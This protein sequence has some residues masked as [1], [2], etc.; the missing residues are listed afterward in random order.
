MTFGESF[1]WYKP[2]LFP[3]PHVQDFSILAPFFFDVD[4]HKS[5]SITYEVHIEGQVLDFVSAFVTKEK[6][7]PFKAN[8]M[9]LIYWDAVP[10]YGR[11]NYQVC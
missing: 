7:V 4:I 11:P 8:W 6:R 1:V 3:S 10:A 2:F 9:L 5:G